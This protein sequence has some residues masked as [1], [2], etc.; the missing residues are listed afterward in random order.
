[1]AERS[2]FLARWSRLKRQARKPQSLEAAPNEPAAA[3]VPEA[4]PSVETLTTDSDYTV[5]MRPGVPQAARNAA[6]QKL[7]RSDPVFANLDGLVEYGEDYAA[8]FKST[9][10]VRTVYQVL[11]GMPDNEAPATAGAAQNQAP[12]PKTPGDD[13]PSAT[14]ESSAVAANNGTV[15]VNPDRGTQ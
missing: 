3:P 9:A 15:S 14:T 6:L 8:A 10:A 13:K 5:F 7:W 4:L 12:T 2:N 1:M 11:K